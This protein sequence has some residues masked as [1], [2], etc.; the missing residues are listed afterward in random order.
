MSGISEI[1]A[2]IQAI[3]HRVVSPAVPGR[4]HAVLTDRLSD[5]PPVSE[6]ETSPASDGEMWVVSPQAQAA[7]VNALGSSASQGITLGAMLGISGGPLIAPRSHT[8]TRSAD[9]G[10]YLRTHGIEA[11]NGRLQRT[12]LTPITGG[13]NGSGYLLPPAAAGWEEMRAAAASDGIDLRVIDSYRS[14]GVQEGAYHAHLR[15]EKTANVLPPGESEHGNGLAVDITNG[16][17]IGV[18]DP[19]YTWMRTNGARF[20]WYPI[21]N[22][23]WHWEFRGTTV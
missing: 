12:D 17:L 15:G 14:W 1:Q 13:W 22:E 21:S 6:S 20:G 16:H 8:V 5:A 23:S 3:Q 9:L 18:G 4:F 11:R 7:S 2:R 10:E 19:E